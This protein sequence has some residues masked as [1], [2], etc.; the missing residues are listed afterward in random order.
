M[1]AVL[2]DSDGVL[3]DSMPSHYRAW[4]TA[5]KEVCDIDAEERTIYLLEGM[6]GVDLVK[7][8][9]EFKNYGTGYING[10]QQKVDLVCE[11]KDRVFRD[12]MQSSPPKAYEEVRNVILKLDNN[13][14]RMAVVSGSARNDVEILLEKSLGK[15][16]DLF[17]TLI[18]ADDSE[19]GKPDPCSFL[20][21]LDIMKIS[22]SQALVVE[23]APL[24]VE[25]ANKAGIHCVVVLNNSPLKVQDFKAV[26]NEDRIFKDIKSATNFLQGWCSGK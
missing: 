6:R 13:E 22:P 11:T 19:K 17:D 2:F 23:N 25:A 4:K 7:R 14:C 15:E 5:F 16:K 10:N 3:V 21:A 12:M 20:S 8:I 24:G 1:K 26:I 9:F 18:T